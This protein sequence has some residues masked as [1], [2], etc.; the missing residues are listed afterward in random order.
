MPRPRLFDLVDG[1]VALKGRSR[2]GPGRGILLVSS[3]GLGDTMLFSLAVRRFVELATEGEPVDVL[4]R[5]DTAAAA[6]LFPRR[7]NVISVDYRRFLRQPL[8]RLRICLKLQ[9]AGY[10]VAVSTDHLRLPT[11]DDALVRACAADAAF[12]LEPRTCS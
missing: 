3:G 6:F 12:A 5:S 10:R 8:Y 4:V 9:D 1:Y 11:V 7:V 2:K